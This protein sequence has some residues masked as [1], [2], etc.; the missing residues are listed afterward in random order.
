MVLADA[1]AVAA[2][3]LATAFLVPQLV[4]LART[5]DPGG[6]SPT[7]AAIGAVSNAAWFAYM[8]SQRL[9]VAAPSAVPIL[10]FYILTVAYLRRAGAESRDA[11][12]RA[13]LWAVMLG[14][15][16]G[17]G[18]WSTLG[19]VLGLSFGLQM[20]PSVWTAYRS[21]RPTGISAG[22]WW[23]GLTEAVLW[24]VYG[25]AYADLPLQVFGLTYLVGSALMLGRYYVTRRR[26]AI[27]AA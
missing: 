27:S 24:F 2:T 3:I 11:V 9:W 6:V 25:R 26:L 16:L 1:A 17:F 18:S 22:T 12:G 23:I 19:L 15:T 10:A 21:P 5:R 13:A 20:V 7:W 14:A 8:L 4:K